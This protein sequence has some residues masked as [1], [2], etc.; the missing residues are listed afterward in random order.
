MKIEQPVDLPIGTT[1][2]ATFAQT[3]PAL[4]TSVQPGVVEKSQ[5]LLTKLVDLLNDIDQQGMQPEDANQPAVAKRLPA[6]DKHLG[7]RLLGLFSAL[8][9]GRADDDLAPTSPRSSQAWATQGDRLQSLVRELASAA[10]EPL[11]EGWKTLLM[12]VESEPMQAV[13]F[14]YQD[15]AIDSDDQTDDSQPKDDK[16]Q[17]AVFDVSFS[18]L[19][20]CQIDAFCQERR[21]DLMIRSERALADQDQQEIAALFKGALDIAGLGGEI[22]FS[23]GGFFE[24]AR[25]LLEARDLHT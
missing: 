15:Q 19:G 14:F 12:P 25:S 10:S 16:A 6:P 18:Q 5:T 9:G 21:F 8:D 17:R 24:P 13:S 4:P 2:Q 20:R 1:L 22:G 3:V 7:S 23:V 11:V